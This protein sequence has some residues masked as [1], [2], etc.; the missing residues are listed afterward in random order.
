MLTKKFKMDS[1]D[2][3]AYAVLLYDQST[4]FNG[5][6][7]NDLPPVYF[8]LTRAGEGTEIVIYEYTPILT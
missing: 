6:S 3:D 1:V 4:Q 5:I 8:K 7:V 2:F